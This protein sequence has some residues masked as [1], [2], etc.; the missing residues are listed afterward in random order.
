MADEGEGRRLTHDGTLKRDP[1]FVPGGEQIL[2]CVD[3]NRV[4]IRLR[5]LDVESG[6]STPIHPDATRSQFEPALSPDGRYL[7]F[8]ECT[9]NLMLKFVIRDLQEKKDAELTCQGRGGM[10]SPT[11]SPDGQRVLYSFAEDGPQQIFSV[12][13]NARDRRQLTRGVG[14]HNWPS[15]TP[16]GETIVFGSSRDRTYEIYSMRADGSGLRRLTR[17]ENTDIRPR[18][19][20]DGK[21]IAFV[22]LRDGNRDVYVMNLDG[23]GVQRVTHNP[24]RDDYPDWHPDG[25]RLVIVSERDGRHDLYLVAVPPVQISS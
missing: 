9:G 14:I 1:F 22:S 8:N 20:P 25:R 7:A 10:R 2:Y 23:S 15:Y 24:E 12:D 16:D 6:E 19:S 3:E 4:Q 5:R 13:V 17:N 21:Q 11:F 18:V